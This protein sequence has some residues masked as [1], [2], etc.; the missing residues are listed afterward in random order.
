MVSLLV[1]AVWSSAFE[2]RSSGAPEPSSSDCVRVEVPPDLRVP[3]GARIQV[4][5]RCELELRK[6]IGR[7]GAVERARRRCYGMQSSRCAT[8]PASEPVSAS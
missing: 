5:G 6:L 8:E 3:L 7:D 2:A 1:A 4:V